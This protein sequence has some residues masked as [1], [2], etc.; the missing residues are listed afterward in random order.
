MR[1]AQSAVFTCARA[2]LSASRSHA[3]TRPVVNSRAMA[4]ACPPIPAVASRKTPSGRIARYSRH[5]RN[6]TGTCIH[7]RLLQ[8]LLFECLHLL[9]QIRL[10]AVVARLMNCF[11]GHVDAA[12]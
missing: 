6:M 2:R 9:A 11:A 4:P 1:E 7:G 3:R 5:S 10:G 8:S 12:V